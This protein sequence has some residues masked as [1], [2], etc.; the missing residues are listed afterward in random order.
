[1][2]SNISNIWFK[3]NMNRNNITLFLI[4]LNLFCISNVLIANDIII[5]Q[6]PNSKRIC[7]GET[8]IISVSAYSVSNQSLQ[9]QWYKDNIIKQGKTTPILKFNSLKHSESGVYYC[10]ISNNNGE[11][12]N[13][14]GAAVYVLSS[15]NITKQP[16]DIELITDQ[17]SIIL[18]FD[19]HINGYS[20]NEIKQMGEFVNIQWYQLLNNNNIIL[21][22]DNIYNGVHSNKLSI[23][24]SQIADTC[25]YYAEIEG[26]CGIEKTRIVRIIKNNLYFNIVIPDLDFCSGNDESI[27]A[28][29]DN[30]NNYELEFKW[31][32]N[33]KFIGYK[34]NIRGIFTDELFFSP[35]NKNDEGTYQIEAKIKGT[36]YSIFSNKAKISVCS[37]PEI[38]AFR[39]DDLTTLLSFFSFTITSGSV[40]F[41]LNCN[42][43]TIKFF[44][45]NKI[46]S[47][48]RFFEDEYASYNNIINDSM[49]GMFS[50]IHMFDIKDIKAKYSVGL[51]NKCGVAYSDTLSI[52]D[53][54]N[55]FKNRDPWWQ[56]RVLCE[57]D[58][59]SIT[60]Y[61]FPGPSLDYLNLK[62]Y[63]TGNGRYL[64]DTNF[65]YGYDTPT[66]HFKN[67]RRVDNTFFNLRGEIS[68]YD[69]SGK[70]IPVS[71][72]HMLCYNFTIKPRPAIKKQA[73]NNTFYFGEKDTIFTL[74]FNNEPQL[75]I[76][77][78]LYYMPFLSKE[79]RLIDKSEADYGMWYN[80]IQDIH[81]GHSGYY[82]A[83]VHHFN[84]CKSVI[85]DT[86]Q[87]TVLP[88]PYITNIIYN[89]KS[90]TNIYPNPAGDFI[91]ISI[92]KEAGLLSREVQIVDLL[93]LVVF[94]QKLTDDINRIDISNLPRGT[95]FIKIGDKVEKFVKM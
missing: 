26:Q 29:I 46:H 58:T 4:L 70:L 72:S 64:S 2:K 73:I 25:Y 23:D 77:V 53:N 50:L 71:I 1:M 88:K 85:T 36:K 86:V 10:M 12:I 19:A 14:I 93:G 16:E 68:Y 22:N 65:Y 52:K 55:D 41:N 49:P 92:D 91:N 81:Y 43:G 63:W 75:P 13:S 35:V 21:N 31:Y 74:W 84:G 38:I 17:G 78:E 47:E 44:K 45:N 11:S 57:G 3:Y 54:L 61:I 51:Y 89:E 83:K 34:D 94:K 79:P 40:Y 69:D 62:L 32:K 80:Y 33:N 95:Y 20:I 24:I 82:F 39:I 67:L 59:T 28:I 56:Y 37:K 60:Q 27:K 87:I 7:E 15:T 9:F 8:A 42:K 6:Q 5:T 18:E 48:H 90:T 30:P 66:L 76:E